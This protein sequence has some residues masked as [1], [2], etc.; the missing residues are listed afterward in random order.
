MKL[1]PLKNKISAVNIAKIST[2]SFSFF[3]FMNFIKKLPSITPIMT[4]K[5]RMTYFI[6][7]VFYQKIITNKKY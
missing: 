7:Y 2:E 3:S 5:K 1:S 4:P 6:S